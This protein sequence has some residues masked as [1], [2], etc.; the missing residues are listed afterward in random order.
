V[1]LVVIGRS[2]LWMA[3]QVGLSG[4]QIAWLTVAGEIET[5]LTQG[6]TGEIVLHCLHGVVT[7]YHLTQ[8]R[9]PG[10][11]GQTQRRDTSGPRSHDE[12]R[13]S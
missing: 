3:D 4:E 5:E 2:V 1:A 12:R 11:A 9:V 6:Y 13:K 8:K 10:K 7:S